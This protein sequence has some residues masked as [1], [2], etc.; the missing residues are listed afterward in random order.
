DEEGNAVTDPEEGYTRRLL[1]E[2]S[3]EAGL[4]FATV[5]VSGAI[6]CSITDDEFMRTVLPA[7]VETHGNDIVFAGLSNWR[8]FTAWERNGIIFLPVYGWRADPTPVHMASFF[9]IPLS[10]ADRIIDADILIDEIRTILDR[11]DMRGR[12]ASWPVSMHLL[13]PLAAAEY[14]VM[15]VNGRVPADELCLVTLEQIFAR[16]I[17]EFSGEE[18]GVTLSQDGNRVLVLPDYLVY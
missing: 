5:D 17:L 9:E 7:L 18:L 6:Q 12:L 14:G 1:R 11:R 8:A 2:A 3:D 15:W 10:S 13:F 16:L 4:A